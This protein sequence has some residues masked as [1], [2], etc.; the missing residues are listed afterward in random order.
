MR[1]WNWAG[2]AL[3][4]ASVKIDHLWQITSDFTGHCAV[5][6]PKAELQAR[7]TSGIGDFS[8]RRKLLTPANVW[9]SVEFFV[10]CTNLGNASAFA[11]EWIEKPW[12]DNNCPISTLFL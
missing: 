8:T 10:L 7:R 2:L 1:W 5:A 9:F 6:S 4:C 3:T 11:C 12:I